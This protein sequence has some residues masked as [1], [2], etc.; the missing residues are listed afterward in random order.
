VDDLSLARL[1]SEIRQT[2][3]AARLASRQP[4]A[5]ARHAHAEQV[6]AGARHKKQTLS[7][8][9]RLRETGLAQRAAATRQAEPKY[10]G[11]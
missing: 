2:E 7:P 1:D 4:D 5:E 6:S 3:H 9:A 11:P 8:G 10:A